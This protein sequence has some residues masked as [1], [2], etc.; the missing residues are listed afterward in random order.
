MT[1]NLEHDRDKILKEHPEWLDVYNRQIQ[2]RMLIKN[3][4]KN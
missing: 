1:M 3:S 4:L 2:D